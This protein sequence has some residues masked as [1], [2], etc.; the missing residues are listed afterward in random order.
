MAINITT[1]GLKNTFPANCLKKAGYCEM[2]YLLRGHN[3]I[4]Y[5]SGVYGWNFDTYV[6]G[7]YAISTGYRNVPGARIADT[8][9]VSKY[10]NAARL[11]WENHTLDYSEQCKRVDILLN[12]LLE[13]KKA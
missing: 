6:I 12:S 11:I 13:G 4:G 8:E 9:T 3:R 2:E 7:K 1:K 10:E 5:N